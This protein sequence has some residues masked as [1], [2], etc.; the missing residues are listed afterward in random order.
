MFAWNNS[1]FKILILIEFNLWMY[2]VMPHIQSSNL[3]ST[4]MR[5]T[6]YLIYRSRSTSNQFFFLQSVRSAQSQRVRKRKYHHRLSRKGYIGLQEEEVRT[7][8]M[9]MQ[10]SVFNGF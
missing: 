2:I 8:L 10:F 6:M 4:Y 9:S 3:K 1:R 7:Y 5:V